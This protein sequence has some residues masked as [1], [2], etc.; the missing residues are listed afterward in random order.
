MKKL[1]CAAIAGLL[2]LFTAVPAGNCDV[3][4]IGTSEI[5]GRTTKIV[6]IHK[7]I[8]NDLIDF[9]LATN[10]EGNVDYK[11]IIDSPG[12][13]V[14]DVFP[15]MEQIKELKAYGSRITT[16]CVNMCAS[17]GALIFVLGDERIASK[18]SI[19]M[20]HE[21]VVYSREGVKIPRSE[22]SDEMKESVDKD[23]GLMRQMLLD[24]L[25]DAE[26]VNKLMNPKGNTG[27][28]SNANWFDAQEMFE[29]GIV[30]KLK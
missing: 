27:G 16:E 14:D 5:N 30:T 6:M 10:Q 28:E 20:F 21:I 24:E 9:Y 1:L 23:D 25:H 18:R 3:T 29:M 19:F 2:L 13:L 11:F 26:V 4:P 7:G 12:G 22:W 8:E 15:M 17:G